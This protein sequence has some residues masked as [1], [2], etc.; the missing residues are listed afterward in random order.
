MGEANASIQQKSHIT[1]PL[2]FTSIVNILTRCEHK[3]EKGF[4]TFGVPA[5]VLRALDGLKLADMMRV[6]KMIHLLPVFR[7]RQAILECLS[8]VSII[9]WKIITGEKII[10]RAPDMTNPIRILLT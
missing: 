8:N 7:S 4:S 6:Q 5:T 10:R 1:L 3:E 9:L 2:T